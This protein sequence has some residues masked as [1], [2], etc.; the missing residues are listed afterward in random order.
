MIIDERSAIID[1]SGT[2]RYV[3]RRQWGE[4][5]REPGAA[6]RSVLWIML[7]PSTADGRED[8][9]TV[10]RCRVFSRRWGYAGLTVVN[11][12]ALRSTAPGYLRDHPE[13]VGPDNDHTVVAE[14]CYH[15]LII[16]AWG[17]NGSLRDRDRAM[18]AI[19]R[20]VGAVVHH[21]GL[22]SRGHPKHPLY[23]AGDTVPQRWEIPA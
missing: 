14:L 12:F 8:D 13:P 11:L 9:P 16:A 17:A 2:Y 4:W 19:L 18:R 3:L 10:R 7:N 21:L 5:R 6:L 23:L 20:G 22:T 15:K 1:A